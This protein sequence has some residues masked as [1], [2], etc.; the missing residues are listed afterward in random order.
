MTC[1][2]YPYNLKTMLWQDGL[3]TQ[4]LHGHW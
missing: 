1:S 3:G 4:F 2:N